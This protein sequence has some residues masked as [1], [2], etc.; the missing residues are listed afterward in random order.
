MERQLTTE[1]MQRR[2]NY[3]GLLAAIKRRE[4]VDLNKINPNDV[5]IEGLHTAR[6]VL[7]MVEQGRSTD[8]IGEFKV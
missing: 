7:A 5:S 4:L 1:Q 2:K 8:G 3:E 6:I